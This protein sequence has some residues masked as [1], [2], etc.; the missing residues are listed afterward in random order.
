MPKIAKV[1]LSSCGPEVADFRTKGDCGIAEL[2]LQIN[3]SFKK[4]RTCYCGSTSFKLR[5]YDCGQL[6]VPTSG[7]QKCVV[8]DRS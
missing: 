3:R 6:R 4:L 8:I 2:R 5:N 7:K 1:K